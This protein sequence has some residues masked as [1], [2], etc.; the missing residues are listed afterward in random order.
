MN[1]L[2]IE[3]SDGGVS[4]AH[5]PPDDAAA[6]VAKWQS[7]FLHDGKQQATA[8][9]WKLI[10]RDELIA[11]RTFRDAWTVSGGEIV[12]DVARAM[13]IWK[14]KMRA[15]RAPKLAALDVEYQRADEAGDAVAKTAIAA[16]KKELRDVTAH[17]S[18]TGAKTPDEIKAVWPDCLK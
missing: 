10:R 6:Y 14:N 7:S 12:C 2:I 11:D 15:A 16:R 17:P 1:V 18:L 13:D 5:N 4:I 3:R 8:L 9:S